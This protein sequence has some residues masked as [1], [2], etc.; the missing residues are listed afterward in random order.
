MA[1]QYLVGSM[2][3]TS[4]KFTDTAGVLTDPT[5]V[6]LTIR[7]PDGT[8][9]AYTASPVVHDGA[10]LYH[11]DIPLTMAG[12]WLWKWNGDGAVVAVAEGYWFA[13]SIFDSVGTDTYTYDPTTAVG[14]VRLLIDDRDMTAID[15]TLPLE[16]RSVIF[17]DNEVQTFLDL[18]GGD[19]FLGA[20]GATRTIAMNRSLLVQHRK[21]SKT[22]V[23]F[24]SLRQ[25]LLKMAVEF[26]RVARELPAD[27][28]AEMAWTD[29]A[30][31]QLLVNQAL[32]SNG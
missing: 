1:N 25:D 4:V 19:I 11:A 13:L 28:L 2:P 16:Q 23:D 9:T 15:P 6:T 3:T 21:I 12:R 27:G 17:A 20:A 32:R 7:K 24:G 14:K 5:I 29:P 26:E 31:R 22:E 30:L 8:E 10:G 18:N